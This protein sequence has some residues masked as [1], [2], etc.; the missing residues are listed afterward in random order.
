MYEPFLSRTRSATATT[1]PPTATV[2]PD[3]PLIKY[4][5][6]NGQDDSYSATLNE[7]VILSW[8][9]ERVEAGWLDPGNVA[10]ACLEMPCTFVVKPPA[11]TTYILKA[12][13]SVA[14][15]EASVTVEIK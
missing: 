8:D 3:A 6:A 4:F 5:R 14:T 10:L 1:P 11:T 13:N 7:S 2:N 9:W 12:V 15:T